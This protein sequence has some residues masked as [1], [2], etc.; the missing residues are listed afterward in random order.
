VYCGL[1]G[2]FHSSSKIKLIQ[3]SLAVVDEYQNH[4]VEG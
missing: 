2:K 4:R 1:V 3:R